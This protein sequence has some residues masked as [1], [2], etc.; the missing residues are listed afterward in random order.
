MGSATTN[1]SGVL[2]SSQ[3]TNNPGKDKPGGTGGNLDLHNTSD[4]TYNATGSQNVMLGV[5]SLGGQASSGNGTKP[6][7]DAG[8][9]NLYNS[10]RLQY[11]GTANSGSGV[12][13]TFDGSAAKGIW[14]DNGIIFGLYSAGRGGNG[15]TG[16]GDLF[17]DKEEQSGGMGGGGAT[18]DKVRN[19]GSVEIVTAMPSGAVGILASSVGGDGGRQDSG[20]STLGSD[21]KG[22]VGGRTH[23]THIENAGRVKLS[24]KASNLL[25]GVAAESYGGNGGSEAQRGGAAGDVRIQHEDDGTIEIEATD[26][27]GA[28]FPRGIAGIHAYVQTGDGSQ[29]DDNSNRGGAGGPFIYRTYT[30]SDGSSDLDVIRVVSEGDISVTARGF[31]P[32]RSAGLPPSEESVPD[33]LKPIELSAQSGGIVAIARGGRGGNSAQPDVGDANPG[34]NGGGASSEVPGL[35]VHV[36][37]EGGSILTYGD[38]LSGIFAASRAGDGGTGRGQADAGNGDTG[39]DVRVETSGTS[40]IATDGTQAIGIAAQS[41]GGNGGYQDSDGDGFVDLY[42]PN[43]GDSGNGGS[44]LLHTKAQWNNGPAVS[45]TGKQAHAIRAQSLGGAAGGANGSFVIVGFEA[46]AGAGGDGGHVL[47]DNRSWLSTQDDFAFGILAQSIGG[48]G[49]DVGA[50]DLTDATGLIV[51]A[52]S[53]GDGGDGGFVHVQQ[54]GKIQTGRKTPA[55]GDQ[56][57]P[58]ITGKAA[59]GILAQSIGGGGGTAGASTG[60]ASVGGVAGSNGTGGDATIDIVDDSDIQT[61]GDF[62][63]GL[64]SQSIGGGG[65]V[66]G[67]ALA[68][69][70]ILPSVAVGGAGGAGGMGGKATVNNR[71]D[72]NNNALSSGNYLQIA[73][74]GANAHAIVA[75]SLGGGGGSGGNAYGLDAGVTG[76]VDYALGAGGGGDGSATRVELD[77][78]ALQTAGGHANGILAQSVGGS[79]GIGGMAGGASAG[80]YFS[81]S[82]SVG[83][84]GGDGGDGSTVDLALS[85]GNIFTGVGVSRDG[86]NPSIVTDSH[87]VVAQSIGGG[88]GMGGSAYGKAVVKEFDVPDTGGE[89][90]VGADT[91]VSVGGSG[92]SGGDGSSVKVGL[93]DVAIETHGQGSHGVLAQSIGGGGGVGG[94][95]SAKGGAIGSPVAALEELV[96]SIKKGGE[97]IKTLKYI[98]KDVANAITPDALNKAA[99]GGYEEPVA[100]GPI[101]LDDEGQPLPDQGTPVLDDKP[102]EDAGLPPL[103]DEPG[104]PGEKPKTVRTFIAL[105]LNFAVGGDGGDGGKGKDVSVDLR[106][107]TSIVTNDAV[108][109]GVLMQSISDGGGAAGAGDAESLNIGSGLTYNATVGIGGKGG[110]GEKAGDLFLHVDDT[111]QVGTRGNKSTGILMQSIG[112]GGGTSEGTSF[113]VYGTI[114]V[115]DFSPSLTVNVGRTGSDGGAGGNIDQIDFA[116]GIETYGAD[117]D[118]LVVQSIGGSGGAGGAQGPESASG[119]FFRDVFELLEDEESW[120]DA[121][122][123][124]GG[125]GGSG[126]DGGHIGGL[127]NDS[128][129]F[130][131]ANDDGRADIMRYSGHI[132]THG[133]FADGMVLQSIGAGGGLGGVGVAQSSISII[134]AIAHGGSG[135]A[136][137]NGGDINYGFDGG[138][139]QTGGNG[140]LGVFMQSIGG[141]GGAGGSASRARCGRLSIG[142]GLEVRDFIEAAK[143]QQEAQKDSRNPYV[144]P[145]PAKNRYAQEAPEGESERCFEYSQGI[146]NFDGHAGSAGD[147][148]TIAAAA[149]TGVS[150][151]ISIATAGDYSPGWLLQSVGA[152]GGTTINGD[153]KII[154]IDDPT[155][156]DYDADNPPP[157]GSSQGDNMTQISAIFGG[158]GNSSGHGG[159]IAIDNDFSITT[160]G[161]GAPAL[162]AQSIG[163]GGGLG[164]TSGLVELVLGAYDA[165]G[166]G[167]AVSVK[168]Q[169]AGVAT[170]GEASHAVVAQSVGGG[171]G[172]F[173]G[174]LGSHREAN[175][176]VVFRLGSQA[177]GQGAGGSVSIDMNNASNGNTPYVMTMG[178]HA[179]GLVAQSIGAGGGL[180]TAVDANGYGPLS[181]VEARL[182]SLGHGTGGNVSVFTTGTVSTAGTGADAVLAQSIG[183]GGGSADFSL[184]EDD[185]AFFSTI[186]LGVENASND[187]VVADSGG[188]VA[189]KFLGNSGDLA[190]ISTQGE[191]AYGVLLQT[192]AGGGGLLD[193]T[194]DAPLPDVVLGATGIAAANPQAAAVPGGTAT[195][196]DYIG[197]LTTQGRNAHGM[198][199]Q[200]ITGGGG[201]VRSSGGTSSARLGQQSAIGPQKA[202]AVNIAIGTQGGVSTTGASAIGLV[203]Q[204]IGG[205]GGLFSVGDGSGIDRADLGSSNANSADGGAVSLRW[206]QGKLLT[207]GAGA[208]GILAQSIGGGGGLAGNPVLSEGVAAGVWDKTAGQT[209]T[210]EARGQ[211]GAVSV[212]VAGRLGVSGDGAAAVLAQSIGGGGGL[213]GTRDGLFLGRT[214]TDD[215][216]AS[217]SGT[218]DVTVDTN[219]QVTATG[220]N[221]IGVLAQSAGGTDHSGAVNVEILGQ[222][223]GGAGPDGTGVTILG[224]NSGDQLH[225]AEGG[226]LS[227]A[228]G[229]AYRYLSAKDSG[230][231][232]IAYIDGAVDGDMEGYYRNGDSFSIYESES[233]GFDDEFF[234]LASAGTPV[235]S[236]RVGALRIVNGTTG[237]LTGA[238][239]YLADVENNGELVV[240][241]GATDETLTIAGDFRQTAT[242]Q[243][244]TAADF[245][246]GRAGRVHVKGNTDLDGELTVSLRNIVKHREV[247]VLQADGALTGQ[248]VKASSALFDFEQRIDDGALHLTAADA[249][250]N[251]GQFGLNDH[252]AGIARYLETVYDSGDAGFGRLLAAADDIAAADLAGMG[253]RFGLRLQE[254]APGALLADA[255]S[256]LSLSQQRFDDLFDCSDRTA[257]RLVDSEGCVAGQIRA[258]AIDQGSDNRVGYDGQLYGFSIAAREVPLMDNVTVAG[259]IGYDRSDFDGDYDLSHSE[260]DIFH[261]SVGITQ[262]WNG[263]ALTGAV[264]GSYAWQDTE[265]RIDFLGERRVARSDH[266]TASVGGRVRVA[267][268]FGKP[269][270]YVKPFVDVDVI[271]SQ[272]DGFRE[273]GAGEANLVVDASKETAVR[274][275]PAVE[276]GR[277]FSV[278]ETL[279]VTGAINGGVS[280][281]SVDNYATS[282]GFAAAPGDARFITNIAVPDTLGRVGAVIQV[283]R[284]ERLGLG[285]RYDGAYGDHFD[286][287]AG[288][289][290]A[291]W[292]FD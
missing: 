33:A 269:D 289:L 60:V 156:P 31:V 36:K 57:E 202:G 6:G 81:G 220:R 234:V 219:A 175:D 259:A 200:S 37:Q 63:F 4:R 191:Q 119:G 56:A 120:I 194:G 162:I 39:L 125:R 24:G 16:S 137:G 139:V 150:S 21:V 233:G 148:G 86:F 258:T 268:A 82:L 147:G 84:A 126:A 54:G 284:S 201:V 226:T 99:H 13:R 26:A 196:T 172:M 44:V 161:K 48:G 12:A 267:Y 244:I 248:F 76:T 199:V 177:D 59:I 237:R 64:M 30:Y 273:H 46:D 38:Y 141:G 158:A 256:N 190:N 236:Q 14:D 164:Q 98:V 104:E 229:T 211:G 255:A 280:L 222:V 277:E 35:S 53:G 83:G 166:Y 170:Q 9:L 144:L 66:G 261:A 62:A 32:L 145:A 117:A 115:L 188:N 153:N 169:S 80:L 73:T 231:S 163:A 22:G 69:D 165:A 70:I 205:G 247:S 19:T 155:D 210:T 243:L 90:N 27:K 282:A 266:Q 55:S 97:N 213:A 178:R 133:A 111:S 140:A 131:D 189:A 288:S 227:A 65:G 217:G 18:N 77:R 184:L 174:E 182:G 52:G 183:S 7:G 232:S 29:S 134:P 250:I 94:S 20:V 1:V 193:V 61:Q 278:G 128:G 3:G 253:T 216:A 130:I 192:I 23:Q 88:G 159:A 291:T 40:R 207:S 235:P 223:A 168:G 198:V 263:F 221:S 276:I 264:G 101:Q 42:G 151:K 109:Y 180:F 185:Q 135:G 239:Q 215:S 110:K 157:P 186:R 96:E 50:G 228:S 92:G 283:S 124:L 281:S 45:T 279:T 47:V 71:V 245:V 179:R 285:L 167:E 230:A 15:G 246:D 138:T 204:S 240:G 136:A 51:V 270:G 8:S 107:D 112:G 106:D 123:T 292:S 181:G 79:G 91:S 132:R 206:I 275:T 87:A 143:E 122:L 75:Q 197:S 271:R 105:N 74:E 214:S 25:Y 209:L 103:D 265:R 160:A 142:G 34:G 58:Q 171:G 5:V 272:A 154:V 249:R 260:G 11:L 254:L 203:A 72:S 127:K 252:E 41:V 121:R 2:L 146:D 238:S 108:S 290:Q 118:G 68:L 241:R 114:P 10:A 251:A 17:D 116:G 129:Q 43:A 149:G 85:N 218:V 78:F 100:N 208:H 113:G 195:L 176:P 242:G 212:E 93:S 28:T 287:H 187:A 262:H 152:G 95:A 257:R 274:I 49:G 89:I 102:R 67:S 224:S 286:S 225:V 173:I